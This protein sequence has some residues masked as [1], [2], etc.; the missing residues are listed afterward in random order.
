[1]NLPLSEAVLAF[2]LLNIATF[3][4]YGLDK[5]KAKKRQWRISERNLLL[6]ALIGGAVGAYLGMKTFRHKTLHPQF[7]YGVPACIIFHLILISYLYAN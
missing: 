4:I 1:M 5:Y 7:R 6:L 2:V 3:V